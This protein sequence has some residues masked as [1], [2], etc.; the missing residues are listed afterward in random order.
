MKLKS[1]PVDRLSSGSAEFDWILGGGFPTG[2]VAVIAG[3][4]GTGKTVFTLQMMF[5]L[6]R[7]GRRCLYCTTLS[8]PTLK[9]IRYVQG[10]DFFDPALLKERIVIRD[11]GAAIRAD[12][13]A[14]VA[15]QVKEHV[16]R[17]EP[18]LVAIDSAKALHDFAPDHG[19]RRAV[20]YD[21]AVT[22]AGWESTTFLVGEYRSDEVGEL[23]EF[24]VADCIIE[25]RN[26][27]RELTTL[28]EVEVLKLRGSH[29]ESGRHFFDIDASG[30]TFYPRVRAPEQTGTGPLPTGERVSTGVKGL[31]ALLGGGLPQHSA[32]VVEGSTGIGKTV[33]GL[34]FLV[35]GARAG[36]PGV[37]F[38]LEETPEQLRGIGRGF[39][40]DLRELEQRQRL[41][42]LYT[43]PVELS[44]DHFLNDARRAVERLHARRVVFDSLTSAAL[45]VSSEPRFRELIHAMTKHFRAAGATALM[46]SEVP[47]FLGATQLGAHGISPAAD[48]LIL[49]RY[50][51]IEGRLERAI[52]VL[53]ARGIEHD[54]AVCRLVINRQGATVAGGFEGLH[55]V[56]TGVPRPMGGSARPVRREG[57]APQPNAS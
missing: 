23:P 45:G 28:R 50:L 4:P 49:M 3:D 31:D 29:Y 9:L 1:K 47:E 27:A 35:A 46:T 20:F 57:G 14:S 42:I 19:L 38:T 5:H 32:T 25:L 11:L 44:T 18:D 55:G 13:I 48:N 39:G 34:H 10:F 17:D 16:E 56:L 40:W 7:Q 30:L 22:L 37:L 51:E 26:R 15:A 54:T 2:S 53:K 33:L 24:A 21:L 12:G 52:S 6:A 36:E 41:A 8:E 43:S